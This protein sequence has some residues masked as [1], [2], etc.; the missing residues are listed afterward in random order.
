[1][2][3]DKIFVLFGYWPSVLANRADMSRSSA[4]ECSRLINV[5]NVFLVRC[6]YYTGLLDSSAI[7]NGEQVFDCHAKVGNSILYEMA[8]GV[9]SSKILSKWAKGRT[10]CFFEGLTAVTFRRRF[11]RDHSYFIRIPRYKGRY[12]CI[13]T[14]LRSLKKP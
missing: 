14:R 2:N 1:M 6:C 7:F 8:Q 9:N 12:W 3:D 5:L 4:L 13:L 10:K 11:L